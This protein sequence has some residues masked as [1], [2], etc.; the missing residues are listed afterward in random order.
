IASRYGKAYNETVDG[1]TG[2]ASLL[3]MAAGKAGMTTLPT[4]TVVYSTSGTAYGEG[5]VNV[6]N[7][8]MGEVR[9]LDGDRTYTTAEGDTVFTNQAAPT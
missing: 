6:R 5:P 8:D 1:F 2:S 7:L 4:G 9:G 3:D